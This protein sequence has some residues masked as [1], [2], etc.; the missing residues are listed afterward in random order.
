[1]TDFENLIKIVL[2]KEFRE[3]TGWDGSRIGWFWGG[4]TVQVRTVCCD[5]FVS[6]TYSDYHSSFTCTFQKKIS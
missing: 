5:H 2:T 1:M 3:G 4:M 6:V